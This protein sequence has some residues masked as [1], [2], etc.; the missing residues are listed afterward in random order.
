MHNVNKMPHAMERQGFLVRK[1]SDGVDC[2]WGGCRFPGNYTVF[3][4]DLKDC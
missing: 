2:H 3:L 4:H 1:I